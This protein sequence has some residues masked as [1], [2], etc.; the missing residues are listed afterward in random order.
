M[1]KQET[2]VEEDDREKLPVAF[3]AHFLSDTMQK[4]AR[5]K[6]ARVFPRS[7]YIL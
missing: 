1:Y 4:D 7:L 3:N 5:T 6:E 2:M